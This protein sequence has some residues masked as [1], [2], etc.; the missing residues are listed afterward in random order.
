MSHTSTKIPPAAIA[1]ASLIILALLID[2]ERPMTIDV[3]A[4]HAAHRRS[5][6]RLARLLWPLF[7]LGLPGGYITLAYLLERRI[8]RRTGRRARE[9]PRAAWAGWLVH[10]AF[11]LFYRRE[12]PRRPGA[13]RR[14][15]SYPSGHTTATTAVALT[16]ANVLAQRHLVSRPKAV[17]LGVVPPALMG[18]YRVLADDHWATDV[19]GGWL[20]GAA[21]AETAIR[22]SPRL[23]RGAPA[24]GSRRAPPA[25]G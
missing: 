15:D 4:R 3:L 11:K 10:R 24:D 17:A 22:R 18:V 5:M 7:P 6:R 14:S 2:D 23:R 25:R 20:L 21:I 16:V 12:R 1:A 8:A 19:I 13:P 9:I